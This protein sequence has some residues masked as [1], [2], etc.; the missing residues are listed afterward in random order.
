[1][2]E[3]FSYHPYHIPENDDAKLVKA[4]ICVDN[5]V[6]TGWRHAHIIQHLRINDL[7]KH[8]SQ[9]MQGFIDQYGN[10]Y[11]RKQAGVLAYKNKQ[12]KEYHRELLSE[13]LW[14]EDGTPRDGGPFD[15]MGDRY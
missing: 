3:S 9:S 14:D 2:I 1:M 7:T 10:V 6:Y 8:V 15:P 11:N 5:I 13:Y 12:T 4:S